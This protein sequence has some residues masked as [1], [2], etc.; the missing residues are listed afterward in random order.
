MGN[1]SGQMDDPASQRDATKVL[2]WALFAGLVLRALVLTQ[3]GSLGTGIVD[4]QHYRN[5]ATSIYER[6]EFAATPG[7]PTSIRPPLFPALVAGIWTLTSPQNLQ[8]IRV[9]QILLSLATAGLVY[10]LGRRVYDHRT[11]CYAAAICWLYPSLIFFNFLILTETLFTF[12]LIAFVL[13]TVRLLQ[14]PT[15]GVAAGAGVALGLAALTRSV[16]W[17]VPLI[18]CPLLLWLLRVPLSRRALCSALVLAGYLV[19]IVPWA[20]RN[21]RLQETTTVVDTMA[22]INLRMGNYEYTPEDRMWDAVSI[23]GEKSW[24]TGFSVEP[25]V[26]PT[27]GRKEKWAQAKAIEYIQQH[28]AQFVRRAFIK[29]AD[30][31]GLEREYIAGVQFGLFAPPRWFAIVAAVGIVAAYA[32]IVSV[33]AAGVWLAPPADWRVHAALLFPVVLTMG[34]HTVV[35][36]HSRYH[37]PLMPIL[38]LYAA[39]LFVVRRPVLREYGRPA[40]AGA[41]LSVAVLAAIWVRQVVIVDAARLEALFHRVVG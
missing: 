37:L 29:F 13:L 15:A 25:G 36:G 34:A 27:E 33:G 1:F 40:L 11:G 32:V 31:W 35:F 16:L 7:A 26:K 21:T 17:P 18:L 14:S 19:A 10:W 9:M 3:T 38:G 5:L 28:P 22:G 8:A 4:E 12:L 6:Q 20:I 41:A 2:W 39:R 24:V 23:G 30:F